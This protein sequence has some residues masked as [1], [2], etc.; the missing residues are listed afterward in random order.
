M[1]DV[2]SLQSTRFKYFFLVQIAEIKLTLLFGKEYLSIAVN[3]VL[4]GDD[5]NDDKKF[6]LE[7]NI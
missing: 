1:F 2:D 4:I 5:L 7:Q 3:T 6:M